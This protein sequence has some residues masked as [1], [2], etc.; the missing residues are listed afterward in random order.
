M[1]NINQNKQN[2]SETSRQVFNGMSLRY[3]KED[4]REALEKVSAVREQ[5]EDKEMNTWLA[6]AEDQIVDTLD[7]IEDREE[8]VEGLIK[9]IAE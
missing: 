8:K 2:E 1:N 3:V 4:L 7:E 9:S 6:I 5:I